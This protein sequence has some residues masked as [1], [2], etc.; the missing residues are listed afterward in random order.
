[1]ADIGTE[2]RGARAATHGLP[3]LSPAAGASAGASGAAL[4]M[5]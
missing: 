4:A 3:H 1:M 5:N 2:P